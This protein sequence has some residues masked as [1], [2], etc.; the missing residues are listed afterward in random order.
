M[1][2][3]RAKPGKWGDLFTTLFRLWLDPNS[4]KSSQIVLRDMYGHMVFAVLAQFGPEKVKLTAKDIAALYK[5]DSSG[6]RLP[7]T[8]QS[9]IGQG[10]LA[11][12]VL[13][14][15]LRIAD[16]MGD[17]ASVELAMRL[18]AVMAAKG[19]APHSRAHMMKAWSRY[20]GLSHF[21]AAYFQNPALFRRIPKLLRLKV[22]KRAMARSPADR[23]PVGAKQ[24]QGMIADPKA[25]AAGIQ[26]IARDILPPYIATAERLRQLG[27]KYYA[28]NQKRRGK[29]LLDPKI[30][31]RIPR[32][33]ELPKVEIK[34]KRLTN[35][36]RAAI[37][38]KVGS[39]R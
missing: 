10:L 15:A 18:T 25:F 33:F 24:I 11:G 8:Y 16:H 17:R 36:E 5:T 12:A 37:T 30:M 22:S 2:T 7:A 29:P 26:E 21:F 1:P 13:L 6:I 4:L 14:N 28:P 39:K 32:G 23:L 20:R 35:A 34:F 9:T 27:E 31:W 3:I 19:G 38:S